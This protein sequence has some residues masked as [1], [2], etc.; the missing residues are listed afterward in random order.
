MSLNN[1]TRSGNRKFLKIFSGKIV[2]EFSTPQTGEEV[3]KRVNKVG[4]EVYY[5]EY[6]SISGNITDANIRTIDSLSIDIIELDIQDVT[7]RYTLSIPVNSRFGKSFMV[8]MLNIDVNQQVEIAP[9][10]FLDKEG[11][12]VS[13][14]TLYQGT[15]RTKVESLYSRDNPNG[16]PEAK[17]IRKGKVETWDFTDQTNFLYDEFNKFASTIPKTESAVLENPVTVDA[18]G[19]DTNDFDDLPF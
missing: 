4:N 17:K 12:Q 10:S 7:E 3:K 16:M 6:D 11:K 15:D 2:Q 1:K 19:L 8:K 5:Y 13:G 14:V 9:Y 18:G